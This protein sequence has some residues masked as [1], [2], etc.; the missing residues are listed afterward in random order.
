[1]SLLEK[2]TNP[3]QYSNQDTS[4]WRNVNHQNERC[5]RYW[6]EISNH[7]T[8]HFTDRNLLDIGCGTGWIYEKIK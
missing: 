7:V 2:A 1:M 4:A 6:N 5:V 8:D 3:E